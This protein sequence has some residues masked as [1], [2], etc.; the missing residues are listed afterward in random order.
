MRSPP[1][2]KCGFPLGFSLLPS[3]KEGVPVLAQPRK[4]SAS[5]ARR[6][7][8]QR[9][10]SKR[11]GDF[12][13]T[14]HPPTFQRGIMSTFEVPYGSRSRLPQ[15]ACKGILFGVLGIHWAQ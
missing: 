12:N 5:S 1:N 3:K 6:C 15:Q 9:F 7:H 10:G 4:A 13:N 8:K 14:S 2:E 11:A